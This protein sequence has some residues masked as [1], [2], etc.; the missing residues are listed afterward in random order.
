CI[1]PAGKMGTSG[2]AEPSYGT[3]SYDPAHPAHPVHDESATDPPTRWSSSWFSRLFFWYMG[4]YMKQNPLLR[5]RDWSSAWPLADDQHS[6]RA[7]KRFKQEYEA[8][9]RLWVA[10]W[11]T[12]YTLFLRAGVLAVVTV[13]CSV[14]RSILVFFLLQS[15]LADVVYVRQ[16][17]LLLGITCTVELVGQIAFAH[18]FRWQRM[19]QLRIAGALRVL[20]VEH[21][22]MRATRQAIPL[23][24]LTDFYRNGAASVGALAATVHDLWTSAT[25]LAASV[26]ILVYVLRLSWIA[27]GLAIVV[28][29]S[30]VLI[31]DVVS[32]HVTRAWT[33]EQANMMDVL[34]ECFKS[35]L[36][37]KLHAWEKKATT[38]IDAV[39]DKEQCLR[40]R[41]GIVRALRDNSSW[42]LGLLMSTAIFLFYTI[43]AKALTPAAVFSTYKLCTQVQTSFYDVLENL[44]TSFHGLY[45]MR[46]LEALLHAS[47]KES[48][49]STAQAFHDGGDVFVLEN[50]QL[51]TSTTTLLLSSISFRVKTGQLVVIHG[52][53]GSGKSTL[54]RALL[55]DG[56]SRGR[57]YCHEAMSI[58]YCAQEPWLQMRSI[59]DNIVSGMNFDEAKYMC[60]LDGCGLLDD[61]AMLADGDR[62]LVGPRGATLSGGQRARVALAR[63]CY[64]NADI[65]VLDDPLAN[66]DPVLQGEIFRKCIV[67]LLAVKTVVL[68]T[69]NE[70]IVSSEMVDC[71]IAVDGLTASVTRQSTLAT[72][73]RVSA[74]TAS[75]FSARRAKVGLA[76]SSL[77]LWT[78]PSYPKTSKKTQAV[79]C[80]KRSEDSSWLDV[81]WKY[82]LQMPRP[83]LW[84]IVAG[85]SFTGAFLSGFC[86]ASVDRD[87]AL[88]D[89]VTHYVP[90]QTKGLDV[91]F[92]EFAV[93]TALT[94]ALFMLSSL[95]I[96]W[97][98]FDNSAKQFG[99]MIETLFRIPVGFFEATPIGELLG[100][101]ANDLRHLD[102]SMIRGQSLI[103]RGAS[104]LLAGLGV[105]QHFAGASV[106]M[107]CCACASFSNYQFLTS[108]NHLEYE[109]EER[110]LS[111]L[112]QAV[113]GKETIR[114]FT[115]PQLQEFYTQ[116]FQM[117][118]E[119][120]RVSSLIPEVT[121]YVVLRIAWFQVLIMLV[122][123]VFVAT[124]TSAGPVLGVVSFHMLEIGSNGLYLFGGILGIAMSLVRIDRLRHLKDKATEADVTPRTG[125]DD[126]WPL[127]GAIIF[128]HVCMCYISEVPLLR[129]VSF[130]VSGGEKIGVVGRT[131]SGKSSL[132]MALF[133]IR[134]LT[135]GRI[136]VD[137]MD[138]SRLDVRELRRRLCIVPQN[139]LFYKCTIQSY[140]DPFSIFDDAILWRILKRTGIANRFGDT[141]LNDAENWS[142]G[143]R[144]LLSF[145]RALL[146]PSRIMVFDECFSAC[147]QGSDERVLKVISR[148]LAKSTVLLIT[149]RV[150]QLLDF[151]KILVLQDGRAVEFGPAKSLVSNP[152]SA[153][154]EFLEATILVN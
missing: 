5:G 148:Y 134:E 29:S 82:L 122:L 69:H 1:G 27:I 46:A 6:E 138:V 118:D 78:A 83:N 88:M 72:S 26:V 71:V 18:R 109:L 66:V 55:G 136:L 68:T 16:A 75:V 106:T 115:T 144:Q 126:Q 87:L 8:A 43:T 17:L 96:V 86:Q 65:Y 9:G 131:G 77:Q 81:A 21:S 11:R 76:P 130:E 3:F 146:H 120:S 94:L 151:D 34:H 102:L 70:E 89:W 110:Q 35:I 19:M 142:A 147:H 53:T 7:S 128:E 15:V 108:L 62:T 51:A 42:S 90:D 101:Y 47:E 85:T 60:V 32:A 2:N 154:Y 10:M 64:S 104:M 139:P 100:Y 99:S 30:V 41:V 50:A 39:R 74:L 13:V 92:V 49:I 44:E 98:L 67:Q 58:A 119:F 113:E 145:S 79:A 107:I 141:L 56:C 4:S 129:D 38:R 25:N 22:V 48:T 123:A 125:L 105:V 93:L 153:F 112:A 37:I 97:F 116:L 52:A 137:G 12:E 95:S 40:R 111:F 54:L 143:E 63:A 124:R 133:R 36:S 150:E 135:T 14:V 80:D 45:K 121:G 33:V 114:L 140:L 61:L 149:H 103:L 23:A 91:K 73:G 57:M 24:E 31:Q 84:T 152:D 28:L 132:A 59:R 127:R 20:L 117:I